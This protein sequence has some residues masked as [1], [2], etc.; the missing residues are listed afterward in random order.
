MRKFFT[1]MAAL[2][3]SVTLASAQGKLVE[4]NAFPGK[5]E[6]ES[7][8]TATLP[9]LGKAKAKSQPS[10][11]A[12]ADGEQLVGFYNTD[13][14]PGD[15]YGIG[16]PNSPGTYY[17]GSMFGSDM[18]FKYRGGQIT[19]MRFGLI[20]AAGTS[21]VTIYSVDTKGNMTKVSEETVTTQ[22]GWNDVTFATPVTVEEGN[23]YL[24]TYSY[25][26]DKGAYPLAVDYYIDPSY[27]QDGGFYMSMDGKNYSSQGKSFG[28]LCIQLVIKGG[29]ILEKDLGLS[30]LSVT[31]FAQKGGNLSL[32]FNVSNEGTSVPGSYTLNVAIDGNVVSTLNTPVA[33]T[34]KKQNVTAEVPLDAALASGSHEVSVSVATI[35]GVAPTENTADDVIKGSFTAYTSSVPRQKNLIEHFTSQFCSLCPYGYNIL[36]KMMTMRDDLAWVS[37]HGDMSTGN[38]EYTID[39]AAYITAFACPGFPSACF[40]RYYYD[41]TINGGYLGVVLSYSQTEQ[42][43]QMFSSIIDASNDAVANF[44]SVD[45][46]PSYNSDT[47][48]LDIKVTGSGAD[49]AKQMLDGA[50]L[51]VYLTED[52]LVSRQNNNGQWIQQ[53]NH[54]NVLRAVVTAPL[55]DNINWIDGSKY[56]NDFSVTLDNS[57]KTENMNVVA[58]IS[59]PIN[60]SSQSGF[61]TSPDDAYVYNTNEVKI[62]GTTGIS[63]P[64]VSA[65]EVKEV[66]RYTIDGA[67]VSSPVKGVNI[68]KMSD[69]ST[70]KV[71]VK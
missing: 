10:K 5:L 37:V 55:G 28:N 12:L 19:K 34:D 3:L 44:A 18:L 29:N 68:V 17:V 38:D 65:G 70:R 15:D 42:A 57:W 47:R 45:I 71:I 59:R 1:I 54:D 46:T 22:K 48:K 61:T 63:T 31:P 52:G 56:E 41:D 69:G 43:A 8:L 35:D 39:D 62:D 58:F 4:G 13:E 27:A 7:A 66:A 26:Q 36:N 49:D 53:Y 50:V 16:M 67:R 30:G 2:L 9:N 6:R 32:S 21:T 33:L 14:L 25:Q 40:N 23:R 20:S 60:Y 11:I 51:T 24:V 64:S